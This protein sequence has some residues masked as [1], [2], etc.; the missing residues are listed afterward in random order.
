MEHSSGDRTLYTP[1][2]VGRNIF[3]CHSL[4]SRLIRFAHGSP[5]RL[6]IRDD[7][8]GEEATHLQL[9]SD[10][11]ALRERVR[12]QLS[13]E[14]QAALDQNDEVYIAVLAAG[15]YEYAVAMLAVLSLGAAVVPM[16]V[17]LPA[18]EALYFATKSRAAAV[19]VS[20]GAL[21]LGVALEKLIKERD[22]MSTFNCIPVASSTFSS[23]LHPR[24]LVTS[25]DL[26]LSDNAP[27]VV[28]F[29]SGTTGP[30]KGSVMRRGYT[31]EGALSVADHYRIT[32]DDV[33]LHVLPVH[34]ATGLG[35]MF[36]P[37][38]ISGAL[39]EFKSG[40]FSPEWTWDR[41]RKGGITFFSGV[42]TIYM[43]MQRYYEQ[44]LSKRPD[45]DQYIAGARKLRACLCG[46]SALPK[47]I[48]DFWT[49]ILGKKILLRYG[50][51]EI[52]AV[53]KVPYDNPESVPDGSVGT[54]FAGCD[55]K[56][57]EGD[58][59]EIQVKSPE[60]FSK[61]IFD[62]EATAAAHTED[63][64]YRTGDIARRQGEHYWIMGRAS[65]D[66]IKSGGYKISALDIEREILSLPYVAEVMVV[67]VSDEEFGERVA[68]VVC[69]K[70][71]RD[72]ESPVVDLTIERLRQDL[73]ARLAGYKMPTMLRVIEAELPKSG[74]GKVVKKVL[75]PQFFPS[76]Y[77]KLPEVQVWSPKGKEKAMPKSRL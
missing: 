1:Q 13:T 62:P 15:G 74:T 6:C 10:V 31:F 53:Y 59:G 63:G 24:L 57:S 27:G 45:I 8:T 35:I 65:V 5:P 73:R 47:P 70:D 61:Y 28:I 54:L 76:D 19:L 69:L 51:T 12:S 18:E 2:H 55:V 29:T 37:F 20:K 23:Q 30:P 33:L 50:A 66:I 67:G 40:S 11:L 32:Q 43:R 46:T 68:S 34:H 25:S 44:T 3:P 4:F 58:E 52:G 49:E 26:F 48:A 77:S 60:M 16:T 71:A 64:Y 36:F 9:L 75:G 7:N 72:V 22:P 14:V 56:L 21:R 38:I 41:W 39:I 17:A 42:P